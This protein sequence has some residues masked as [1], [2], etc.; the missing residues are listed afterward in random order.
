MPDLTGRT[1]N[2]V[3]RWIK[4]HGFRRGVVR[5]LADTDQPAGTVV[6]HLPLAGYPIR[7]KEIVELAVAE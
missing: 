3:E 5:R 4:K 1:R 7:E 2:E 6:A